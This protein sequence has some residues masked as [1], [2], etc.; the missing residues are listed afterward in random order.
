M[1]KRNRRKPKP[2]TISHDEKAIGRLAERYMDVPLYQREFASNLLRTYRTK[3]DLSAKQW[4]WVHIMAKKVGQATE[5]FVYA[6]SGGGRVKIGLAKDPDRRLKSLQTGNAD[7]L[8]IAGAIRCKTRAEARTLER[9]IHVACSRHRLQG[10][11]F[12]DPSLDTFAQFERA[13]Q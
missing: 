4:E 8:S 5:H 10:E 3:G 9:R 7:K 11:W 13:A 6:V 12:A 1:S 2:L